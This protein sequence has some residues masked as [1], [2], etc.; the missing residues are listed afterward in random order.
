MAL[1]ND[2]LFLVNR[3]G[4]SFKTEY[5]LLKNSIN[6]D[7]R[8]IVGEVAPEDPKD[9]DLWFNSTDEKLYVW[10]VTE[11][12]G[13]VANVDVR[14]GG[15]GY[16]LN[17]VDIETTGGSGF[18]LTVDFESSD[19]NAIQNPTVNEGGYGYEIGD[20]IFVTGAGHGNASIQV[21]SV[22]I[23]SEGEWVEANPGGTGGGIEEAPTDGQQYARQNEGWSVVQ[24]GD[25]NTTINYS[26][27]SAWGRVDPDGTTGSPSL[28]FN[29]V[30]N[31]DGL[32]TVTFDTPMGSSNYSVVVA[33][34]D[35]GNGVNVSARVRNQTANGFQVFC[36][37]LG[38]YHCRT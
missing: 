31:S 2:D 4:T 33:P 18:G 8:V 6:E 26:G 3:A 15:S 21:Q 14:N 30:K 38:S 29:S 20:V 10:F 34:T 19:T 9:G 25:N 36:T 32:Y 12:T 17:L 24:G 5:G 35:G 37:T 28:N 22:N 27:A 7:A 16:N 1:E 13:V 11:T 23:A